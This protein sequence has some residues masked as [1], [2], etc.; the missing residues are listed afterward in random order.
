MFK[1]KEKKFPA[2]NEISL[3]IHLLHL[4]YIFPYSS[5]PKLAFVSN[6]DLLALLWRLKTFSFILCTPSIFWNSH[7]RATL[8]NNGLKIFWIFRDDK[9]LQRKFEKK[10]SR[11]EVTLILGSNIIRVFEEKKYFCRSFRE[12]K[13][14]KYF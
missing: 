10:D 3:K 13:Y 12:T 1:F 11:V 4:F 8:F 7:T 9:G 5:H 6:L 14:A 2:L